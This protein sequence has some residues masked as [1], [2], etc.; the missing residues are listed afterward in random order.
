MPR[1]VDFIVVENQYKVLHAIGNGMRRKYALA[2]AR[3]TGITFSHT[4]KLISLMTNKGLIKR[5][6]KVGRIK[7]LQLSKK[8][9]MIL[10][11]LKEIKEILE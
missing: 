4:N 8:G 7:T 9:R 6:D 11:N 10:L 5:D 3:K 2:I 1:E